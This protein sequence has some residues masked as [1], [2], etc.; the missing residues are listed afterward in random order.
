MKNNKMVVFMNLSFLFLFFGEAHILYAY[1]EIPVEEGGELAGTVSFKG[2]APANPA[3]KV[4]LNPEYCGNTVY[5]ET[6]I[7]NPQNKG[8]KNAVISVEG[9]EKGKKQDGQ[10]V[11][12]QNDKCHFVPHVQAG[13]VGAFYEIQNLDPVL[14]NNHFRINDKTILNV[15]M[16]PNGKNI[17][18]QMS[19]AGIIKVNCDAHKFMKGKIF[20][21]ENPYFA[22]TDKEGR[23]KISSIPPGKYRV[24]IWHEALLPQE[25]EIVILPHK[26]ADLSV[27]ISLK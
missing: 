2:E 22:V 20:V 6:Y 17:K 10:M 14:H 13:M 7:V 4:R 25:K 27:E 24:K 1:T 21:G 15:A 16:P 12:L 19:E 3:N 9:I 11:I 23:Y 26:K 5:D 8:L 18:K